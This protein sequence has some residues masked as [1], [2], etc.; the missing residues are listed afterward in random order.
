MKLARKTPSD[1]ADGV[2]W[3]HPTL[4]CGELDPDMAEALIARTLDPSDVRLREMTRDLARFFSSGQLAKWRPGRDLLCMYDEERS[5]L[6]V[7]WI[8]NKRLPRRDDYFDSAKLYAHNPQLTVAIRTYGQA[9]GR[10]LLTK[11]FA[12]H[13]LARLLGKRPRPHSVWYETKAN[14]SGARALGRQLGFVEASG[15]AGGTV[16][17]VRLD[18]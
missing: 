4:R 15:E 18:P 14:N 8:A 7:L 13:A 2:S 1:I 9:R 11:S 5:L 12:E 3:N 17:G 6:G 10:G 16:V